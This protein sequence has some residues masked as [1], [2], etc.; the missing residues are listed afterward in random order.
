MLL[1]NIPFETRLASES[2]QFST[3]NKY[4]PICVVRIT[5]FCTAQHRMNVVITLL[6]PFIE[7]YAQPMR[8]SMKRQRR[9][10]HWTI[11]LRRWM[12]ALRI[13]PKQWLRSNG[14][15]WICCKHWIKLSPVICVFWKSPIAICRRENEVKFTYFCTMRFAWRFHA[16][17]SSKRIS[18]IDTPCISL[19]INAGAWWSIHRI[20]AT[21][22]WTRKSIV[23]F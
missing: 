22:R 7:Q 21:C 17:N 3:H 14:V 6:K 4:S 1:S 9:L 12:A 23:A 18:A 8:L 10:D 13:S 19:W 5:E 16:S 15:S 2:S 20:S 11:S